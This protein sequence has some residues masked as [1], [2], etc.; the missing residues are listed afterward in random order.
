M[1]DS[2]AVAMYCQDATA[3]TGEVVS[4]RFEDRIRADLVECFGYRKRVSV[5]TGTLIKRPA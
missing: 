5:I 4:S 3:C 2:H 1:A